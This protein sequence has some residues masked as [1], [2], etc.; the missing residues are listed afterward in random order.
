MYRDSMLNLYRL[1]VVSVAAIGFASTALAKCDDPPGPGVDWQGCQRQWAQLSGKDLSH[2][3][4]EGANLNFANL[5]SAD[6][7]HA[8]LKGAS[9]LGVNL[10]GVNFEKANLTS[11]FMTKSRIAGAS[12]K[13]SILGDAYWVNGQHC[14]PESVGECRT[15][16]QKPQ[17]H[18]NDD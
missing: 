16:Y 3:N 12:F 1:V 9:L 17:I 4:L 11:T 5:E 10:Q 8:N 13:G 6:L 14:L 2:A 18:L 7:S 15:R